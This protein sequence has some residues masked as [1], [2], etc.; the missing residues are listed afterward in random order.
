MDSKDRGQRVQC[1]LT[2]VGSS[3][4]KHQ[5][6]WQSEAKGTAPHRWGPGHR[7]QPRRAA[8]GPWH[9]RTGVNIGPSVWLL[10]LR[11]ADTV[12]SSQLLSCLWSG[13]SAELLV[14]PW[15]APATSL[16]HSC[17]ELP[18]SWQQT[19]LE[20][21]P[22]P[23]CI[24]ILWR[25]AWALPEQRIIKHFFFYFFWGGGASKHTQVVQIPLHT[26]R[27]Q[28]RHVLKCSPR[29]PPGQPTAP[30]GPRTRD[31][32][33]ASVLWSGFSL[34]SYKQ[35]WKPKNLKKKRNA[36]HDEPALQNASNNTASPLIKHK[37]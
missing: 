7:K 25:T 12:A 18:G 20:L 4:G 36:I 34:S 15:R 8:S 10:F 27:R 11:A 37:L 9:H 26:N 17:P 2:M 22:D 1:S 16:S 19:G 33:S 30:K 31:S 23:C 6:E 29:G 24:H 3:G 5:G 35:R 28:R 14:D 13:S 32:N 21:K